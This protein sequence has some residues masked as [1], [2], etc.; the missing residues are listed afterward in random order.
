MPNIPTVN[1]I[2]FKELD[3]INIAAMKSYQE[4]PEGNKEAEA[5][6]V[7]WV[8]GAAPELV[9]DEDMA[10]HLDNGYYEIGSGAIVITH[11]TG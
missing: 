8:Q 11:S 4:T 2:D 6:F 1:V 5:T 7:D 3:T 9:S 10:V